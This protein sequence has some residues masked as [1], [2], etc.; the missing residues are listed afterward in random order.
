ML[1]VKALVVVWAFELFCLRAIALYVEDQVYRLRDSDAGT[2]SRSDIVCLEEDASL[3]DLGLITPDVY[4]HSQFDRIFFQ[5]IAL[6]PP[7]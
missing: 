4:G 5:K 6:K 1:K 3:T 2:S 7:A